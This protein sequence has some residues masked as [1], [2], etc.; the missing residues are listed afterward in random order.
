[1]KRQALIQAME[2]LGKSFYSASELKRMFPGEAHIHM[3]IKRMVDTRVLVPVAHGMYALKS[4]QLNIEQIGTQVYYP[5][6]ISFET[7]LA[8]YG[9]IDQGSYQVRLATIRHSK[10]LTLA[11]TE[12]N[13]TQ[14]K[15]ELFNGFDLISGTY[16]AQ[17]EKAVLDQLYLLSLGK[18]HGS[19]DEWDLSGLDRKRLNTLR[20]PY[21]AKVKKYIHC[22]LK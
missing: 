13:Y 11:G 10:H 19:L 7:A 20:E 6:Y 21:G 22:L 14:I 5:S 2:S 12:C 15:P 16:I 8:K 18:W 4:E 1:M 17:P 3:S 9:I